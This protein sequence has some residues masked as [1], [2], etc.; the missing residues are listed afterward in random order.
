MSLFRKLRSWAQYVWYHVKV[1]EANMS[2]IEQPTSWY[3]P[4]AYSREEDPPGT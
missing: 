2:S 3:R 1:D 4:A